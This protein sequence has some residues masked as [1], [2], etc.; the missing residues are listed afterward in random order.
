MGTQMLAIRSAQQKQMSLTELR[1]WVGE[2]EP[3]GYHQ[4]PYLPQGILNN[5]LL[6]VLAFTGRMPRSCRFWSGP[7]APEKAASNSEV[8]DPRPRGL[9]A[10]LETP[11][12]SVARRIS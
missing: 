12:K 11:R 4:Q 10:P 8:L 9:R 3:E 7:K 6:A 2:A 5:K 1:R